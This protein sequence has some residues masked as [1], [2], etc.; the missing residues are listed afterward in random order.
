VFKGVKQIVLLWP[1]KNENINELFMK[2]CFNKRSGS[3]SVELRPHSDT[4]SS[5]SSPPPKKKV[6]TCDII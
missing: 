1:G 6:E 5:K 4:E 3:G 2:V